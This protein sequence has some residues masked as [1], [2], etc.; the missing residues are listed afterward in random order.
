MI[1]LEIISVNKPDVKKA[2]AILGRIFY[3]KLEAQRLEN[4]AKSSRKRHKQA[5]QFNSGDSVA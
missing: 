3:K 4:A 1:E 5:N 2:A